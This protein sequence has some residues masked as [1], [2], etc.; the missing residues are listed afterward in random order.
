MDAFISR[1]HEAGSCFLVVT[2]S[3]NPEG[4]V[5]QS[6]TDHEEQAIEEA[7]LVAIAELN[8]QLAPGELG[9][10]GAVVGATHMVPALDLVALRVSSWLRASACRGRCERRRPGL[11]RLPRTRHAQRISVAAR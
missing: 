7:L 4:R 8:A 9:P 5:V 3:S 2:R 6:A 10:I 11:R 1:A